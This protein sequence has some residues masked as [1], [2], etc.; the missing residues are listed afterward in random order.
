M[1]RH[2]RNPVLAVETCTMAS[3]DLTSSTRA[4]L[5]QLANL[6]QANAKQRRTHYCISD[7]NAQF[8]GSVA[9]H[10]AEIKRIVCNIKPAN[11]VARFEDNRKRVADKLFAIHELLEKVLFTGGLSV[12]DLLSAM[13]VNKTFKTAILGSPKL[14]RYMS[15]APDQ[16]LPYRTI[17]KRTS[18][19]VN[20]FSHL[21]VSFGSSLDY[22]LLDPD[23]NETTMLIASFS[24]KDGALPRIGSRCR[25]MLVCRP[26]VYQIESRTSCCNI[27]GQKV[28]SSTGI[29]VGDL[30]DAAS[31][32]VEEH[33]LCS[34]AEWTS[35]DRH[36]NVKVRIDFDTAIPVDGDAEVPSTIRMG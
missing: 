28:S 32:L 35:H 30:Y 3:S 9:N 12:R 23:G 11:E 5:R 31:R 15:L 18:K 10:I 27:T 29:T 36:G 13:E 20:H 6:R 24:T 16:A 14:R 7:A 8:H 21:C 4:I 22:N 25:A 1:T 2:Y 26:P 19:D 17:F 33:R 34:L